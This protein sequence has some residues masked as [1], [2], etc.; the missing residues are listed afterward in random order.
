MADRRRRRKP[1]GPDEDSEGASD[2]SEE[3]QNGTRKAQAV[4][5]KGV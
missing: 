2:V 3:E 5:A 4:S 1:L